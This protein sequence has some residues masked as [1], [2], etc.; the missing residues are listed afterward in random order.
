V[1]RTARGGASGVALSLVSPGEEAMLE[2]IRDAQPRMV[3]QTAAD[4]LV[5]VDQTEGMKQPGP[6]EFDM[7]EIEGF[8]Y[9]VDDVSRAVTKVAIKETR[10][11]ELKVSRGG[12][13]GGEG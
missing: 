4:E 5:A 12:G 3:Q 2:E 7:K 10:A 13:R 9:R 11:A 6:L 8:R 1:G